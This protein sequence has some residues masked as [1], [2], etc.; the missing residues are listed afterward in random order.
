MRFAGE[1]FAH[2]EACEAAFDRLYFFD[3]V[4]FETSRGEGGCYFLSR[5]VCLDVLT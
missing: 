1:H 5:Q 4:H 2:D 3:A